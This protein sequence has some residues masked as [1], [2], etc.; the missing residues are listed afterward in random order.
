MMCDITVIMSSSYVGEELCSELGVLPPTFM[1]IANKYLLE[2]Q[3]QIL[4]DIAS[5][6]IFYLT[7]PN[8]YAMNE[9][10]KRVID[11][12]D[13]RVIDIDPSTPLLAALDKT[14]SIISKSENLE[15]PIKLLL[16][17][18]C[19]EEIK[20]NYL[21]KNNFL[22]VSYSVGYY[23]RSVFRPNN[24]SHFV[25][26]YANKDDLVW[27]GILAVKNIL[28]LQ[29]LV[30]E[31]QSIES[32]L[33]SFISSENPT[34]DD[35]GKWMDCGHVNAYHQSRAMISTA[36]AFNSVS[37]DGNTLS[38]RSVIKKDKIIEEARWFTK[39]PDTLKPYAPSLHFVDDVNGVYGIE[40]EYALA[41]S[42]LWVYG[43]LPYTWWESLLSQLNALF[44]QMLACAEGL[45]DFTQA[46][47]V[48]KDLKEK[49][50]ARVSSYPEFLSSPRFYLKIAYNDVGQSPTDI[51]NILNNSITD[52]N[53]TKLLFSHGDLCFSNILYDARKG[54]IKIIDPKGVKYGKD[55]KLDRV[56]QEIAKLYHSI[57]GRYD[58]IIAGRF[59]IRETASGDISLDFDQL[60][61]EKQQFNISFVRWVT[62]EM[63]VTCKELTGL[64][65]LLFFSMVPLHYDNPRR[66]R[67]F[68]LNGYKLFQEW[69]SL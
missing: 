2:S 32:L 42:E 56:D 66:Q 57:E 10:E 49:N 30:Q 34:I 40:Y 39:L 26:E 14:I 48:Q 11:E 21:D 18:T 45:A 55:F 61:K 13:I 31:A 50:I 63:G 64:T 22:S 15:K 3:L 65:S 17:D 69:R 47:L 12:Y 38:K 9:S 54:G 6:P 5:N 43:K 52:V 19:Y 67:A 24:I 28:T 59:T 37:L 23:K 20:S 33:S 46:S 51:V 25:Y 4:N 1:P 68:V 41:L 44:G 16:G 53:T 60:S 27:S 7:L 8:D 62:Q 36:R 58:E 35:P 29:T